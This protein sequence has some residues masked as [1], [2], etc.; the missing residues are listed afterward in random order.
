MHPQMN[1][2]QGQKCRKASC[3]AFPAHHQAA[4]LLLEPG[5]GPLRLEPWHRYVER[6]APMFLG[7]PDALRDLRADPAL[8]EL[9]AQ[10]WR[11]TACIRR[12]HLGAFP[13]ASGM[14]CA[15]MDGVQERQDL[16]AF[17]PMGGR[18]A[19][20]QGHA[21]TRRQTMAQDALALTTPGNLLTPSFPGGKNAINGAILPV[22]HPVLL[23][24]PQHPGVHRRQGA[25]SLPTLQPAMGGTL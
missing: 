3:K 25:I 1:N 6:S 16:R 9:L 17:I 23:G 15:P 7:L 19:L 13:W 12:E 21:I 10:G 11:I 4:I 20:G 18:D 8:T 14:A 2:C 5:K 24:Q 22:N